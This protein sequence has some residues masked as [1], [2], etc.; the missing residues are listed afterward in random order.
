[1]TDSPRTRIDERRSARGCNPR[2]GQ[3]VGEE[4][5]G[6]GWEDERGVRQRRKRWCTHDVKRPRGRAVATARVGVG[7]G[8]GRI[9]GG[10]ACS[11]A[12]CRE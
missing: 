2:Q 5:H 4:E 9:R 6:E 11:Y 7:V 1:M 10:G 12:L 8:V 3:Q